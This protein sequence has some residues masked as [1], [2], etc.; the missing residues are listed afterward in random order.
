MWSATITP[1]G[2]HTVTQDLSKLVAISPYVLF[3]VHLS[4]TDQDGGDEEENG[5][6]AK[7]MSLLYQLG[8]LLSS[9]V[10]ECC[11]HVYVRVRLNV[12]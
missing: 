2:Q 11:I 4:H 8:V 12:S 6:I 3:S 9:F 1:E 7:G 5:V 10:D